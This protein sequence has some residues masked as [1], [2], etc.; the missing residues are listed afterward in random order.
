[1]RYAK[2]RAPLSTLIHSRNWV[3]VDSNLPYLTPVISSG[4]RGY[5]KESFSDCLVGVS[6][7]IYL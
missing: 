5:M 3:S 4:E 7:I 2:E 6:Y 1:M